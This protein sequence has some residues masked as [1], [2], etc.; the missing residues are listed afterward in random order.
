MHLGKEMVDEK[1]IK[2][3]LKKGRRHASQ[4]IQQSV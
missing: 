2:V 3:I 4:W 1:R